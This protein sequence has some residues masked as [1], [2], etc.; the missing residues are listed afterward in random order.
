MK[1]VQRDVK[2]LSVRCFPRCEDIKTSK[3]KVV[4]CQDVHLKCWM[5]ALQTK[6][7]GTASNFEISEYY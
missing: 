6:C 2:G 5:G 4:K 7:K 1:N 3:S